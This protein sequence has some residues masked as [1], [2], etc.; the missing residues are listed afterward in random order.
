MDDTPNTLSAEIGTWASAPM[1]CWSCKRETR[2]TALI[3][4]PPVYLNDDG[5]QEELDE[6]VFVQNIG[7]LPEEA[8]AELRVINPNLWLDHSQT[9]GQEYFM[10][11]CRH[12]DAK[13]GD[14]YVMKLGGPLLPLEDAGL[15][16]I[17]LASAKAPVMLENVGYSM[18]SRLADVVD[19]EPPDAGLQ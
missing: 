6:P 13:I 12:C 14:H 3:A 7:E 5:A 1:E 16:A 2:V 9:A 19:Y 8:L 18:S 11:H 17:Q 4:L 15:P 10:N